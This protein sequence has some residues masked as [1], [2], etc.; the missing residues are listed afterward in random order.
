MSGYTIE[1]VFGQS[2]PE[3]NLGNPVGDVR[4][5]IQRVRGVR[6]TNFRVT[7][8]ERN[9]I[10]FDAP[11]LDSVKESRINSIREEVESRIDVVELGGLIWV[12]FK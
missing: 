1:L 8:N 11:N 5:A 3:S 9:V 7:G 10:T 2:I 12:E 6:G 4:Q